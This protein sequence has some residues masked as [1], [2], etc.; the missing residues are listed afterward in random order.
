MKLQR[1]DLYQV[2]GILLCSFSMPLG[3]LE[4]NFVVDFDSLL[5]LVKAC[6]YPTRPK[7][8]NQQWV[9]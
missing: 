2:T 9:D 6:L 7:F 1:V 5:V 8:S 3:I 4:V